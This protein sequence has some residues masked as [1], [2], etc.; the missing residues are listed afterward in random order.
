M[1]SWIIFE[2]VRAYIYVRK[3]KSK[4]SVLYWT[5]LHSL[6][7]IRCY[8]AL[9][10]NIRSGFDVDC[11]RH[12]SVGL[13]QVPT[14]VY[15]GHFTHVPVLPNVSST[16]HIL[17]C[18]TIERSFALVLTCSTRATLFCL[19]AYTPTFFFSVAIYTY[20]YNRSPVIIVV[21]K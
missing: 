14:H 11:A 10:I 8:V 4:R 7:H 5:K 9:V 17:D 21:F 3:T 15:T 19:G 16:I 1:Y 13:T 20:C 18:W 2:Y 12:Y 6:L